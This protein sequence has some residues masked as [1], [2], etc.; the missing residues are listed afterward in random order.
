MTSVH[1]TCRQSAVFV[2]NV[3]ISG[4]S[5]MQDNKN[6]WK[7]EQYR[8]LDHPNPEENCICDYTIEFGVLGD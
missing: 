3:K 8:V 1:H 5:K 7:D 4:R 2:R 6:Y